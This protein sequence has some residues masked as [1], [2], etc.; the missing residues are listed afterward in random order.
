PQVVVM[1]ATDILSGGGGGAGGGT[2]GGGC[3]F[4]PRTPVASAPDGGAGQGP[5][6]IIPSG[7]GGAVAFA[8][9]NT[10]LVQTR[11]PAALQ[12]PVAA[13]VFTIRLSPDSRLDTGHG[14][15]H[16]NSGAGLACASCHPEGGDDGRVWRF[17][18]K[19]GTAVP[20]RTQNLR[21]GILATAPFHW[22]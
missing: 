3:V 20:R 2:G 22:D 6:S 4:P 15:F 8:L 19:D 5:P 16:A 13:S 18:L 12:L 10:L 21:G 9:H 7:E 11:E 17:R 1:N 14:I